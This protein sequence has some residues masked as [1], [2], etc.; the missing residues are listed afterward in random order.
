MLKLA[1]HIKQAQPVSTK[2][3]CILFQQ[4][5]RKSTT[6]HTRKRQRRK[7]ALGLSGSKWQVVYFEVGEEEICKR[8]KGTFFF[9]TPPM[10]SN[11]WQT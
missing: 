8:R 2:Q 7:L 5:K 6:N 4:F 11:C 10:F 9:F 1:L 3:G